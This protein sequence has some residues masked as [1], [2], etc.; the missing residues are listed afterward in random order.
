MNA[1]RSRDLQ[2]SLDPFRGRCA[3]RLATV[4]LVHP[5]GDDYPDVIARAIAALLTGGEDAGARELAPIAYP[6]REIPRRPALPAR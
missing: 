1:E 2:L 6:P 4:T 5:P 3:G